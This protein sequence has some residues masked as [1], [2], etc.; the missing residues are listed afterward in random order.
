MDEMLVKP[1]YSR[2]PSAP[3][4][5]NKPDENDMISTGVAVKLLAVVVFLCVFALCKA[6]DTPTTNYLVSKVKLITTQNYDTNKY[7]VGA[8][9][10]MGIKLPDNPAVVQ[11]GLRTTTNDGA[12]VGNTEAANSSGDVSQTPDNSVTVNGSEQANRQQTDASLKTSDT[13]TDYSSSVTS[14]NIKAINEVPV[15][16]EGDIKAVADK[17][18]FI[19]PVNGEVASAFGVMTEPLSGKTKFHSGIDIK[20]NKGTS[21]KAALGGEVAEVGTSPQYG[22]YVKIKHNDG[23]YTIYA[24]CS[25]LVA[26]KGQKINQGDVIAKVGDTEGLSGAFLH[27]EVWKNDKAID[28]EKLLNLLNQ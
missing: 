17:Y 21:I 16:A 20:A 9:N 19:I 25:I 14:D 3:R 12:S 13:E 22:K 10:Y 6:A 5:K 23:L 8:A 24:Q 26:K 15:L 11:T 4:R 2:Q 18:S 7:I 28:P 27:F 1:K